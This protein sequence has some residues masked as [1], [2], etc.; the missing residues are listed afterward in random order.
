MENLVYTLNFD[1][2]H[3]IISVALVKPTQSTVLEDK[4][5]CEDPVVEAR[6]GQRQ[7]AHKMA[8]AWM[9]GL[10][11]SSKGVF[12]RPEMMASL[13]KKDSSESVKLRLAPSSNGNNNGIPLSRVGPSSKANVA[14]TIVSDFLVAF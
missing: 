10:N 4:N 2:F 7:R 6:E 13:E 11:T 1:I 5:P 9:E 14:A 3:F 12:K 8:A